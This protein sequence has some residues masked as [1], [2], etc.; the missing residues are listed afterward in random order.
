MNIEFF[1]HSEWTLPGAPSG[2][3]TAELTGFCGMGHYLNQQ[4]LASEKGRH[5][6]PESSLWTQDPPQQ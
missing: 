4:E 6:G 2:N 5:D 3:T 1:D